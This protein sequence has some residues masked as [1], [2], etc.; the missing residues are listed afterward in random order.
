MKFSIDHHEA[1]AV[2]E[3]W[4]C[5]R[6]LETAFTSDVVAYGLYSPEIW[7]ET[8][9][10]GDGFGDGQGGNEFGD[11]YGDEFFLLEQVGTGGGIPILGHWTIENGDG[12]GHGDP[13]FG[14]QDGDGGDADPPPEIEA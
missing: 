10:Y 8:Y 7:Y 2:H 3:D 11:G 1:I 6:G 13:G 5:E 4:K 12:C 14:Y 9:W